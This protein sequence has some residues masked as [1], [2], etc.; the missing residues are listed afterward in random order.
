MIIYPLPLRPIYRTQNTNTKQGYRPGTFSLNQT[1]TWNDLI[2]EKR[3]PSP[4]HVLNQRR[5]RNINQTQRCDR[6]VSIPSTKHKYEMVL[7][8]KNWNGTNLSHFFIQ[9]QP[10][11]PQTKRSLKQL[12]YIG[13]TQL[14]QT[15]RLEQNLHLWLVDGNAAFDRSYVLLGL[16]CPWSKSPKS[17]LQWKERDR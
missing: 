17:W 12:S 6:D 9:A 16:G 2:P 10:S 8:Q 3:S 13:G 1:Q 11:C 14:T 15:P 4:S 7:F 5:N